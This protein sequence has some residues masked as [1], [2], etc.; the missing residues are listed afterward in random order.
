MGQPYNG[1][2]YSHKEEPETL[3]ADKEKSLTF[4]KL[5]KRRK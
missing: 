3:W 5:K 1:I 2:L 4:V